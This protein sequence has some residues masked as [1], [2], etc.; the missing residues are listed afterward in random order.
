MCSNSANVHTDWCQSS[1]KTAVTVLTFILFQYSWL[2]VSHHEESVLEILALLKILCAIGKCWMCLELDLY[3]LLSSSRTFQ[4]PISTA[5]HKSKLSKLHNCCS[6]VKSMFVKQCINIH[7]HK[8]T[9]NTTNYHNTLAPFNSLP[10]PD[11]N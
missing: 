7:C 5:L 10:D 6:V 2:L 3:R 4:Q 8:N 11:T 1:Q 9:E